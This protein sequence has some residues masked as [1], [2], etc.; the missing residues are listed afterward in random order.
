MPS[1]LRALFSVLRRGSEKLRKLPKSV[2]KEGAK[3]GLP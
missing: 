2:P 3:P 1:T